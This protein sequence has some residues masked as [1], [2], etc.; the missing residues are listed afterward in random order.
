MCV[1]GALGVVGTHHGIIMIEIDILNAEKV[2][3]EQE[4]NTS[5]KRSQWDHPFNSLGNS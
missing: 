5:F 1:V 4:K 3:A 2:S